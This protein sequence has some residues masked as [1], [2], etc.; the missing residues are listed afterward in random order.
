MEMGQIHSPTE[1]SRTT[2]RKE[3]TWKSI[4]GWE[5]NINMNVGDPECRVIEWI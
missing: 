3:T 1:V 2:T 5:N 4:H